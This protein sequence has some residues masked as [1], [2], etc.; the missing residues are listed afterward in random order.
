MKN[1]NHPDNL[2]ANFVQKYSDTFCNNNKPRFGFFN[3][4]RLEHDIAHEL[5]KYISHCDSYSNWVYI[6]NK[7]PLLPNSSPLAEAIVDDVNCAFKLNINFKLSNSRIMH[8]AMNAINKYYVL[9]RFH[10]EALELNPNFDRDHPAK[11]T[12]LNAEKLHELAA[13]SAFA[14]DKEAADILALADPTDSFL[15]WLKIPEAYEKLKSNTSS[16]AQK[17]LNLFIN[18]FQYGPINIKSNSPAEIAD[19][20]RDKIYNW[21]A[22][23]FRKEIRLQQGSVLRREMG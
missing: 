3:S 8:I 6:V 9:E 14:E 19:L 11:H 18:D 2:D 10:K 20:M 23:E 16:S 5:K 17:L 4:N 7:L 21:Y 13:D 12:N 15:A 1:L 22:A